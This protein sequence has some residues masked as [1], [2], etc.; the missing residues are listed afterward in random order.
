MLLDGLKIICV[1]A[2]GTSISLFGVLLLIGFLFFVCFPITELGLRI[3]TRLFFSAYT[4]LI[5][6][7]LSDEELHLTKK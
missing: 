6:S 3:N 4:E 1:F 5:A 2:V 7:R